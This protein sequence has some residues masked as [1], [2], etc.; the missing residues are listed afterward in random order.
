MPVS[1]LRLQAS[2][3]LALA[4]KADGEGRPADAYEL[5]ASAMEHLEDAMSVDKLRR[6]SMRPLVMQ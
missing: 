5:T 4:I 1:G 2:Q 6:T 3:L